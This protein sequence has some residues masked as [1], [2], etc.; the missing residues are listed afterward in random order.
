MTCVPKSIHS[1]PCN[2]HITQPLI[3]IIIIIIISSIAIHSPL[4]SLIT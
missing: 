3:I 4:R 2:H 1:M